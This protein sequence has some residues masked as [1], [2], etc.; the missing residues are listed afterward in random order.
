MSR[1]Y[2]IKSSQHTLWLGQQGTTAQPNGV[3]YDQ[4]AGLLKGNEEKTQVV[5]KRDL[6]KKSYVTELSDHKDET[7]KEVDKNSI[8]PVP[9]M[10]IEH[11]N[12]ESDMKPPESN[13][14]AP[15]GQQWNPMTM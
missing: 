9:G 10:L 15:H 7:L 8:I 3:N 2:I 14:V 4:L 5:S 11:E 6:R 1:D 12:S 13:W